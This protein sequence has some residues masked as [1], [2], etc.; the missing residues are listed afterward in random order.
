MAAPDLPGAT[1][2]IILGRIHRAHIRH[3]VLSEDGLTVDASALRAVARLG[4]AA[5]ARVGEG[6]ELSRPSWRK[7]Q[8]VV[9]EL[10]RK[11]GAG[12]GESSLCTLCGR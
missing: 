3:S 8:T 9:E 11:R 1:N 4:G 12:S 6:F 10:V 2:T 5:Y 7:E